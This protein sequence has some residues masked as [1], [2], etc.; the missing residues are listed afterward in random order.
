MPRKGTT[1]WV[2]PACSR[3]NQTGLSHFP[4]HHHSPQEEIS[5][6]LLKGTQ[7]HLADFTYPAEEHGKPASWQPPGYPLHSSNK[8]NA[9]GS[10]EPGLGASR[11]DQQQILKTKAAFTCCQKLSIPT[12]NC[13]QYKDWLLPE[14]NV[15]KAFK[16]TQPAT[17]HDSS[18][19]LTKKSF[20]L[21]LPPSLSSTTQPS[22]TVP[23]FPTN[24]SQ[25]FVQQQFTLKYSFSQLLIFPPTA[26]Y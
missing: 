2:T 21:K 19:Y 23:A 8:S 17:S 26:P 11:W 7:W 4:Q 15:G 20:S 24:C 16:Q 5:S 12:W 14:G 10:A 1:H 25:L 22:F 9:T 3:K 6:V 13:V 18:P